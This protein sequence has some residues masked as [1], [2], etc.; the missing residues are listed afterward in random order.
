MKKDEISFFEW[1]ERFDSGE[2]CKAYLF[3]EQWPNGFQCN[4]CGRDHA[5]YLPSRELYQCSGCH[6]QHSVTAGTLF[7][8]TNL[9]LKKWFWAIYFVSIDKG[10]ISALRLSKLIGV[11]WPTARKILTKLREAMG[12][13]DSLYRLSDMI[14]L[15]DAFVGGKQKGKRGRGAEGKT[16]IIVAC[17]SHGDKAGFLAIQA[18]DSINNESVDEFSK[19]KLTAEQAIF[20]DAFRGLTSLANTQ[21]HVPRTTPAD[22]VDEWLPWVHIVIGNL[23]RFILGTYHGVQGKYLQEYI[24][25]FC[26]RFNRRFWEAEIPARLLGA[27]ANHLPVKSC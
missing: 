10:G 25:E 2:A 7:H 15:D 27:C 26:Y 23:K 22:K 6:K 17:E 12:H 11:S 20:T 9:S 19:C 13:R 18:V 3:N 5:H 1:Q 21:I 14:E 24:N 8:S 16:P 4:S